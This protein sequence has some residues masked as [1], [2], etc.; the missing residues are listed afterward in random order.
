MFKLPKKSMYS[1]GKRSDQFVP[2]ET[3]PLRVCL[4]DIDQIEQDIMDLKSSRSDITS[5]GEQQRHLSNE[6]EAIEAEISALNNELS[7]KGSDSVLKQVRRANERVYNSKR[8]Y[9][10]NLMELAA[11]RSGVYYKR[12]SRETK[13]PNVR[14]EPVKSDYE[15]TVESL[16]GK[17]SSMKESITQLSKESRCGDEFDIY[18]YHEFFEG[19][20][21]LA[22]DVHLPHWEGVVVDQT[23]CLTVLVSLENLFQSKS[24]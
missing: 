10:Q 15:R 1:P 16:E 13:T 22:K 8:K 11:R 14:T 17:I 5:L 4:E 3:P 20:A 6:L 7:V 24:I 12:I 18:D 2:K 9:Q 19:V 23:N 21:Q